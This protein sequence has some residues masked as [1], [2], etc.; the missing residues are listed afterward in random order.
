MKTGSVQL[1]NEK[2]C[3]KHA[4]A[5]LR[6]MLQDARLMPPTLRAQVRAL[7][8]SLSG[9]PAEQVPLGFSPSD[10]PPLHALPLLKETVSDGK[11]VKRLRRFVGLP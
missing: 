11:D 10:P 6:D 2:R 8:E 4:A 1:R 9:F 3:A 5:V 7:I